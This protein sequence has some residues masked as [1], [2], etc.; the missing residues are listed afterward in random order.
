MRVVGDAVAEKA[1]KLSPLLVLP[2][3]GLTYEFLEPLEA[4][5]ITERRV[6]FVTFQPGSSSSSSSAY[7]LEQCTA[8]AEAAL[9]ALEAPNGVHVLAHGTAAAAAL[10]LRAARPGQVKSLILA[11]PIASLDDAAEGARGALAMGPTPLLTAATSTK[12]RACV[13]S[14]IS[15]AIKRPA[16]AVA[17]AASLRN[18]V[19]APAPLSA[20]EQSADAD[21]LRGLAAGGQGGASPLLVTRGS[22]DVSSSATAERI[23]QRV[24]GAQLASFEGSGALA[25]VDQR[26][27]YNARVLDF[28]DA[29]D[30][31]ATRRSVMLPGSMAPGGSVRD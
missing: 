30:G 27:A 13:D 1:K 2:P 15:N 26:S 12:A 7:S 20:P 25:H 11:S 24:P 19:I 10:A 23:V 22:A 8:Q 6:A 18:G 5:T 28:L 21:L 9:D 17:A 16:A 31:V 3:P 4:L 14:E 29:A